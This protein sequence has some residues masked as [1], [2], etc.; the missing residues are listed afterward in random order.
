MNRTPVTRRRAISVGAALGAGALLVPSATAVADEPAAAHPTSPDQH[1]AHG[2]AHSPATRREVA[3]HDQMRKLWEDHIT[4]T[5]LAIVT[6][7]AGSPGFDSTAG[8]L[9]QNQTDIG[10]AI[11]PYY[12]RAAAARLT[13]LLRDHITIAV[14]ILQAAKAGDDENFAGARSRWYA[15]ADDIADFLAAANPR[16][17]PRREMRAAMKAHLDQ[18]LAEAAHELNGQ[19]AESVADYEEIHRHI[20][21]MADQLSSGIIRQFPQRF[22]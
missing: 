11:R 20:L 14:E 3:F 17:W 21:A 19:Y 2:T 10:E 4:W 5:R 1:G 12:G 22:R 7:A 16:W 6:F 13:A 18:T 8:R 15:N 9:L